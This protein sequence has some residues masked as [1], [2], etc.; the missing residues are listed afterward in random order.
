MTAD[1]ATPPRQT[2]APVSLAERARASDTTFILALFVTLAGKPCAKL[3]PVEAVDMLAHEGVG[4][5]G[6]AAG[7]M[8]Q[9]PKDPDLIAIP[10]PS[11]FTPDP[12]HSPG[13]G[14]GA[15]RSVRQRRAVAV[16]AAHDPQGNPAQGSRSRPD[17]ERRR[18]GRVL[19]GDPHRGRRAGHRRHRRRSRAAVLRRA[20]C[21]ADVRP[22]GRDLAGDEHPGLGQLR[23]R[24]RGRQRPVRAELRVR[25]RA[26]HRRPR[27]HRALPALG[28]RRAARDD[29]DVHAQAVRR[30]NRHRHAHAHVAVRRVGP[31]FPDPATPSGLGLSATAT[32]SSPASS[33]TPARCGSDRADGQFLQAHRRGDHRQ[34]RYL[35]AAYG[36]LRRQRPHALPARARR[37]PRRTARRRRLGQPV[38]GR[39]GRHCRGLDG[40]ARGLDPGAPGT[41]AGAPLPPTLLHAVEALE[42]DPV[43]SGRSTPRATGVAAYF[44]QLKREEFFDWHSTVS[45]WEIDRYLTA[46]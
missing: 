15:L 37:E 14:A 18:R 30:S 36:Q 16:R 34:R 45:P 3:V 19:P 25:R 23:Q 10:D 11:S 40:I 5:A 33:T 2:Q 32:R 8:G 7:A 17:G 44:A 12:V 27:H 28:D 35:V 1:T 13:T 26:D 22:P 4:F 39:R 31:L 21:H 43:V 29:G 20:R 24:P 41:G 42:A 46:F 6:Y 38:S 9:Q